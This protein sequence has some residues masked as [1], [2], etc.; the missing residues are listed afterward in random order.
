MYISASK[1]LRNS[2][3]ISKDMNMVFDKSIKSKC[4]AALNFPQMMEMVGNFHLHKDSHS[5]YCVNFFNLNFNGIMFAKLDKI[6]NREDEILDLLNK[7]YLKKE[8]DLTK[9]GILSI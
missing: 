1:F 4:Q 7:F 3:N 8:L 2:A 5:C 9:C 6:N